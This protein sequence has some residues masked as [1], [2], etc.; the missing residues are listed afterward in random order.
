MHGE[1][2]RGHLAAMMGE[3]SLTEV[4]ACVPFSLCINRGRYI[5]I[6]LTIVITNS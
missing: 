3:E 5:L 1:K 4:S 6:C 2:K